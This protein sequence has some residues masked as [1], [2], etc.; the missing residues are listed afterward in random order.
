MNQIN[1]SRVLLC[2]LLFLFFVCLFPFVVVVL[3]CFRVLFL[4]V[5]LVSGADKRRTVHYSQK[6]LLLDI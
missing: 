1:P 5:W 6:H 4:F 3:F 2:F